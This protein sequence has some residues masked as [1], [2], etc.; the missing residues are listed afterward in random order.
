MI[1][2][3]RHLKEWKDY[4][5]KTKRITLNTIEYNDY[6]EPPKRNKYYFNSEEELNE[7][8]DDYNLIGDEYIEEVVDSTIY[9]LDY[10]KYNKQ[11]D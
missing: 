7:W 10:E 3:N 6:G 2:D 11:W 5:I 8:L 9:E 4:L 1:Y